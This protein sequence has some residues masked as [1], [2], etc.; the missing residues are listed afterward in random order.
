MASGIIGTFEK[1]GVPNERPFMSYLPIAKTS[2]KATASGK[3]KCKYR[4]QFY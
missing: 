1:L 2:L 3:W 4:F